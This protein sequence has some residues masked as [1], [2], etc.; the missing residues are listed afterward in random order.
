MT[1]QLVDLIPETQNLGVVI[2]SGTE[3]QP[4]GDE[5]WYPYADRFTW[6]LR[7]N[8]EWRDLY[9]QMA[10][11][12]TKENPTFEDEKEFSSVLSRLV[13]L[14]VPTIGNA[15]ESVI[16]DKA[17]WDNVRA[18]IILDFLRKCPAPAMR[19]TT[20]GANNNSRLLI[21]GKSS[22]VSAGSTKVVRGRRS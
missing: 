14:A 12:E 1:I 5:K 7:I 22:P 21:G 13:A 20:L 17:M 15:V 19:M 8:A 6:G 2:G 16:P 18:S 3:E 10:M 9:Q 4:A 11:L